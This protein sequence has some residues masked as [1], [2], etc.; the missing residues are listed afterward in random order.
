MEHAVLDEGVVRLA[1]VVLE[2]V[3]APA[4]D[5][6][7]GVVVVEAVADVEVPLG[8]VDF[9]AVELVAPDQLPL[10][11]VLGVGGGVDEDA[12]G[13]EEAEKK[14]GDSRGHGGFLSYKHGFPSSARSVIRWGRDSRFR[15]IS[16]KDSTS[17]QGHH[18]QEEAADE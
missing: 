7:V 1:G 8:P 2:F 15:F 17:E 10:V 11:G 18:D 13:G 9:L 12:D 14:G 3:V 16:S 5:P 4:G 6:R